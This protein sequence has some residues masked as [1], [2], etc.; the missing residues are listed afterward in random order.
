MNTL[1]KVLIILLA[2]ILL[3]IV[4]LFAIKVSYSNTWALNFFTAGLFSAVQEAPVPDK[5]IVVPRETPEVLK[6]KWDLMK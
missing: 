6:G 3:I 2:V 5:A 4:F 1:Y